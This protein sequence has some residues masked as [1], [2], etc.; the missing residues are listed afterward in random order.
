MYVEVSKSRFLRREYRSAFQAAAVRLRRRRRGAVG[1]GAGSMT[2]AGA[3]DGERMRT[4]SSGLRTGIRVASCFAAG[5][6]TRGARLRPE[7]VERE[8]AE[9]TAD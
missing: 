8:E 1:I 3:E 9:D 2:G 7:E 6:E 4:Y 5:T